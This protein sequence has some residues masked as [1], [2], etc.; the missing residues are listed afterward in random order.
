[1][2]W[3]IKEEGSYD[4]EYNDKEWAIKVLKD[5]RI[6]QPDVKFDLYESKE[7]E[8]KLDV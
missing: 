2:K 5:L 8:T 3:I 7:V 4:T 1:M 6:N